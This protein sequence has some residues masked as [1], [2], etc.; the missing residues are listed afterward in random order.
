MK[1]SEINYSR[2]N[3]DEFEQQFKQ[4]LQQFEKATT[5][6]IQ[7]DALSS[8]NKLR[9]EF[10]TMMNI[11]Y[12]KHSQ[13]TTDSFF[14]EERKFFDEVSP[15]YQ[16]W[17]TKFYRALL[18]STF[19]PSLE[20]K[21]G[22]QLFDIASV[23]LDTFNPIIIEDLKE[24]NRLASSYTKLMASA[25]I[26]F[27]GEERNLTGLGPF[28][29]SKDREMRKKAAK[30]K[31]GFFEE[32]KDKIDE[33]FDNLVKVRHRIATKLG[34]KSFVELGYKRMIRTDYD[35]NMVANFRQQV[36]DNIVPIVNK[37]QKRRAKR[38]GIPDLKYYDGS[39]SFKT[40]NPT[41]KGS[42]EW[43]VDNGKDMYEAL[44]KETEEFFNFMLD[45]EL[46]DL[47]NRK[48]KAG[49]GYCTYVPNHKSPFIFS[50]FNGTAHDITVLTHEAGHAFQVYMSRNFEIPEYNWPTYEACEIHS[51]S[52]E[53]F[54]W[55]WMK[56]F[57][58]E[59]TEKFKFEHLSGSLS[60]L[61]YGVSVDEFQHVIYEN[62][63]MTPQERKKAW[64]S[65]EQKYMPHI[66]YDE[67]EFLEDGGY[68]QQQSH[69][70][71]TPFYYIDYT[72]AQICA[73]QFW[74]KAEENREDAF[75]DYVKLCKA[76]GSQSFLKLVD[77]ANL[78]SPFQDG[79]LQ[80]VVQPVETYL[81]SV[82][83]MVL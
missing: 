36:K 42:P 29:Q 67:N 72:L 61:P 27:E 44:S 4:L 6:N 53:F 45:N 55:P 54:T 24:E 73:F 22:K 25:K 49:G 11:A 19:R 64:R 69:I 48:G 66:N 31:W 47:V 39:L 71:T 41:P 43:I 40:G 58:K 35:A 75:L 26:M 10:D 81:E 37:L 7:N 78:V 83:D 15:T 38:L 59:D 8:I 74:V 12:I 32:N 63:N 76:G 13:D 80:K 79:C 60:F 5:E 56:Q 65:I 50:N 16:D 1:F 34:Y 14:D 17:V 82:N 30:A 77:Y 2:P 23:S 70:F 62:P 51:M 68:W 57:F 28:I 20:A 9:M 33:I 21:W 3:M 46:M 52:M 18:N